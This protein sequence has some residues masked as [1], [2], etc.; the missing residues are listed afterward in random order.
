MQVEAI[1]TEVDAQSSHQNVTNAPT[2][3]N[4]RVNLSFVLPII[5]HL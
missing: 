2:I 4:R 5:L 3:N 1:I